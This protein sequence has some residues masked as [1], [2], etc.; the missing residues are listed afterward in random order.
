MLCTGIKD[1]TRFLA[2]ELGDDPD[3]DKNVWMK[4][5]FS[6]DVRCRVLL[7]LLVLGLLNGL[8]FL[9][10]LL[11]IVGPLAQVTAQDSAD[12]LPPAKPQLSPGKMNT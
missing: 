7:A 1:F 4:V 3:L 12:F 2:Q 9:P 10:V 6:Y 11:I 8:V 5:I